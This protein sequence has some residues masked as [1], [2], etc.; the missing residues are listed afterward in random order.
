MIYLFFYIGTFANS[1]NWECSTCPAKCGS[2]T[3]FDNCQTCVGGYVLYKGECIAECPEYT[4]IKGGICYDCVA[5]C[6]E[7]IDESEC[8]TCSEDA[9]VD[10]N[11]KCA[12]YCEDG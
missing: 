1:Y 8:V 2:C 7:C 3:A 10:S 11:G 5:P 4:Y 12:L 9:V 6:K